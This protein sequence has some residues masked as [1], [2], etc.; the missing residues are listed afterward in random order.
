VSIIEDVFP[1]V[2]GIHREKTAGN[3][4]EVIEIVAAVRSY[5]NGLLSTV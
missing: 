3:D 1:A 5:F 4:T 2:T